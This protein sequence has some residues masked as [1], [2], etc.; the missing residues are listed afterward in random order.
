MRDLR[1]ILVAA[2]TSACGTTPTPPATS[3]C[4]PGMTI[5]CPCVGGGSGVQTCSRSGTFDPCVCPLPDAGVD[6]LQPPMDAPEDATMVPDVTVAEAAAPDAADDALEAAAE[7]SVPD[8]VAAEVGVD[9]GPDRV[10][11]AAGQ[12]LCGDVCVDVQASATHCGGCDRPCPSGQGCDRGVCRAPMS[13]CRMGGACPAMNYC[14]LTAGMCR[15]GCAEDIHCPT[16]ERCDFATRTC[17]CATGT[18][19]CSGRCVADDSPATC[20]TSCTPC[21]TTSFGTATCTAGVCGVR[22]ATNYH[23]C[24]T[25]CANDLSLMTCG[26]RCAECPTTMN[27]A[28]LCE[29]GRCAI[30]CNDG[31]RACE[32][33]CCQ[34]AFADINLGVA[35][36][37]LSLSADTA[38]NVHLFFFAVGPTTQRHQVWS[39]ASGWRSGAAN[40]AIPNGL[41]FVSGRARGAGTLVCGGYNHSSGNGWSVQCSGSG[42]L[43]TLWSSTSNRINWF[44]VAAGDTTDASVLLREVAG[45]TPG[46]PSPT[47]WIVSRIGGTY[48][49]H[50]SG[51]SGYTNAAIRTDAPRVYRA[52]F[53]VISGTS[54]LTV[55]TQS[56][57]GLSS[58][59]PSVGDASRAG[60]VYDATTD[61]SG[62]GFVLYASVAGG[63]FGS[64]SQLRVINLAANSDVAVSGSPTN[65]NQRI[66]AGSD[67]MFHRIEFNA[68]SLLY[69]RSSSTMAGVFVNLTS[70]LGGRTITDA[71]LAVD[72]ANVPHIVIAT[73]SGFSHIM[74]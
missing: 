62:R 52:N 44:R 66:A 47:P 13:D 68:G 14:D 7:A 9:V 31:Y 42:G 18:H 39:A 8:A 3:T 48:V 56:A 15:P 36:S 33:G 19:R 11:C 1:W 72:S 54:G 27:G 59:R 64:L 60:A 21:P 17:G 40:G 29:A 74:P 12:S 38:G 71:A 10:E 50:A 37:Q 5:S 26:T 28:A 55:D 49:A 67:G 25:I 45:S 58:A 35:T 70:R 61:P 24:G 43:A 51:S 20:G 16:G 63:P 22:C 69:Y 46:A 57:T 41:A 23:L 65:P 32:T 34:P 53:N 73:D 4:T 6:A 30:R 2:M